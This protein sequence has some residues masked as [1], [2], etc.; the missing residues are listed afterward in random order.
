MFEGGRTRTVHKFGYRTQVKA[1]ECS[2]EEGSFMQFSL[3]RITSLAA[4]LIICCASAAVSMGQQ[5][6]M[7]APAPRTLGAIKYDGDMAALLANLAQTFQVPI[8]L[9]VDPRQPKSRVKFELREATLADVLNAIVKAEPR[10]QWRECDGGVEVLPV[11]GG[12]PL[13]ETI[14]SSF[15]LGEADEME[16]INQLLN[17]PE[18][19]VSLRALNLSHSDSVRA[20]AGRNGKKF[21]VSLEGVTMRQA[22]HRIVTEGGGLFWVSRTAVERDGGGLVSINDRLR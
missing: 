18:V 9:E 14:I 6:T 17:S 22:L 1:R 19:Q 16:A 2:T 20:P 5:T 7:P 21:S 11:E 10:Y 8:G 12:S 15:Q 13:L 3:K 4:A